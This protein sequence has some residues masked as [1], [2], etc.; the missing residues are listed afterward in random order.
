MRGNVKPNT[1]HWLCGGVWRLIEE[2]GN[3]RTYRCTKCLKS[4]IKIRRSH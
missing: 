2:I 3:V 1:E 4:K